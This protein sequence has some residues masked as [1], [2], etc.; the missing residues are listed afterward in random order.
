MLAA[1]VSAWSVVGPRPIWSRPGQALLS[2]DLVLVWSLSSL[3]LV[4]DLP[5]FRPSLVLFSS[6]SHPGLVLVPVLLLG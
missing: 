6:L 2:S 4:L 3:A 5:L 1:L